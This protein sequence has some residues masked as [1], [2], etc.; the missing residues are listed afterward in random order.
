[1]ARGTIRRVRRR[2]GTTTPFLKTRIVQAIAKALQEVG[3]ED[4]EKA[5]E[6]ADAVVDILQERFRRRTPGVEGIQDVVEE[7]LMQAGLTQVAKAYI[8]YRNRH[9]ALR[10]S[11]HALGVTDELKLSL[12]AV[13]VLER[14]YLRKD[15]EG[16]VI[17]TPGEMFRRVARAVADAEDNYAP[18]ERDRVEERFFE[19]MSSLRFLP[20]SPTLMN[21]GTPLG[22]LA[23]CFILPVGDSMESIFQT[24]KDMAIIHQTGGGTGFSFSRL[25]PKGDIVA[26]TKGVASGP[27]S[28][29]G[30]F[31]KA[32]DV[33][34][35]GGRRRGANM[36]I[37]RAD[38][39][40]IL[41]FITCKRDA[42]SFRNFNIS[43]AASDGFM[44]RVRRNTY[45]E[46]IN[47]RTGNAV[48]KV[49]ARMVWRYLVENAWETGDP[50]LIFLDEINRTHPTPAIGSIESTNPCGEMPLLPYES[51][52][53]GS[54]N[55]SKFVRE[56]KVDWQALGE[57]VTWCVRFLDDVIDV[58][59]FPLPEVAEVTRGNR[60]IGLGVMGFADMLI[61][62]G[63][64]YDKPKARRLGERLINFVTAKARQP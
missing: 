62:M 57:T 45:Y 29:M 25:R 6:L 2:D 14:R 60:K 15:E 4:K 16:R 64:P 59:R 3:P 27:V 46:L 31:D 53:L 44:S 63:I 18:E 34:R 22:Q 19:L 43:V 55:L 36:G 30:I 38:H 35:Q 61:L 54:I 39:P 5:R 23:A 20:N 12:S 13:K 32:T 11:K 37:L 48:E 47:P 7:V 56:G 24:L 58:Q 50:G 8:L 9:Q 40:D 10:H 49:R 1:M 17:E 28:F 42:V 21:A 51:C 26:S 52:N 33:V 41:E